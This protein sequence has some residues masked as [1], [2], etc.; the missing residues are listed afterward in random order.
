MTIDALTLSALVI[1]SVALAITAVDLWRLAATWA[2][3]IHTGR[4]SGRRAWKEAL[5]R[6]ACA[7]VRRMP[8]VPKKDQGRFV[9]WD[10]LR[11]TY[12]HTSIQGWQLAGLALGIA[13]H[14]RVTGD[15]ELAGRLRR[16]LAGHELV[17]RYRDGE[18]ATRWETDRMLL[19]YA[20]LETG[21]GDAGLIERSIAFLS[22]LK[23]DAGTLAYRA[24]QP[25]VRYVDTIGLACPLA[26]ACAAR[27]GRDD[28][29]QLAVA[30]IE[31]YDRAL[32]HGS[33]LPAHGFEMERGYPLGLYDWSRGIGW[34]ALGLCEVHRHL[35]SASRPE[36]GRMEARLLRLA[37]ELLPLQKKNGGFGWMV[38][39][40]ESVFESSG[41]ALM[42]QLM[43]T[44]F[45]LAG[46][47][48]FLDA[49]H[50]VEKA[51]MGVTRRN[52]ALDMCQGDTKGIG[53]YS[54]M[55]ST[56][57]FAQ[58]MALRLAAELDL[59]EQRHA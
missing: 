26:A 52:G 11:G 57:P 27:T 18:A 58:G 56:M 28:L 9:L 16:A 25:G 47:R 46:D 8:A 24:H 50:R 12:A 41:T 14:A 33:S 39:R 35:A 43:L 55:W 49:A 17:R 30:P 29:W 1:A 10:I 48:R 38:A 19:D 37:E 23:T 20:V 40:P 22:T 54:D 4:W 53:M 45:R 34:Y 6:R 5:A 51:L 2:G 31:E 13:A 32:L 42:G 59:E 21:A 7:W 15:E 3:R 36:A 44:A